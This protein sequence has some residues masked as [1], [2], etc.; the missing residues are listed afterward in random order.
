MK[1]EDLS[2]YERAKLK[3]EVLMEHIG[4][5]V[6]ISMATATAVYIALHFASLN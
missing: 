2:E 1:L 6:I 3:R 4:L 5:T